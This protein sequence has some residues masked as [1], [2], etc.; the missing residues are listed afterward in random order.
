[1]RWRATG[2]DALARRFL[3]ATTE[4]QMRAALRPP[5]V[6][7]LEDPALLDL[8]ERAR[9]TGGV[10]PRNA[11][12]A[13]LAPGSIR[14]RGLF[15]P[16]LV[17]WCDWRVALLLLVVLIWRGRRLSAIYLRILPVMWGKTGALRRADY[18]RELAMGPAAAKEL[19][20]FGLADWMVARLREAW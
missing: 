10:G 12:G 7:H 20:V 16:V 14:A 15:A 2:A 13:L 8:M 3:R 4:R 17:A 5:T 6:A 9:N 1:P 18:L 19:R 11:V